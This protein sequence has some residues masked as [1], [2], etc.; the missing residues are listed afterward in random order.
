MNRGDVL[1]GFGRL[2]VRVLGFIGIAMVIGIYIVISIA[3]AITGS[4][5]RKH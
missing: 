3:F 2:L 1:L 5:L 4:A